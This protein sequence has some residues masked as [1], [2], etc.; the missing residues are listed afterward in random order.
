MIATPEQAS[1]TL[2][3]AAKALAEAQDK[4]AASIASLR[5]LRSQYAATNTGLVDPASEQGRRVAK[6]LQSLRLKIDSA[7]ADRDRARQALTEATEAHRQ[8][9]VA[10]VKQ[11]CTENAST[12]QKH[13]RAFVVAR[14]A[15]LSD[16]VVAAHQAVAHRDAVAAALG[17]RRAG[18]MGSKYQVS[19]GL[20]DDHEKFERL[21][22]DTR[23]LIE[24]GVIKASDVP[25]DLRRVWGL[26]RSTLRAA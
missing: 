11:V 10:A 23:E 22:D 9:E 12:F 4:H 15:R 20:L 14:L 18:R 26:D 17:V 1:K 25:A 2:Q 16:E 24:R 3:R 21:R 19:F 7:I 13:L 5:R 8:A 6:D